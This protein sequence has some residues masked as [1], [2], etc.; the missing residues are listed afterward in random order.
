LHQEA[1]THGIAERAH[2]P[3]IGALLERYAGYAMD[4]L[5]APYAA[6]NLAALDQYRDNLM[7]LAPD[8]AG[9]YAY[10]HYGRDISKASGF[11]QTGRRVGDM[12]PAM[13][14]ATIRNYDHALKLGAA[15]YTVQRTA[16]ASRASVWESLIMPVISEAGDHYILVFTK[17]V[18]LREQL[19]AAVL[20]SSTDGVFAFSPVRGNDGVIEDAVITT[21][22]R[23]GAEIIGRK[24][25]SLINRS[26][27]QNLP[28]LTE[29]NLW[30]R[31]VAVMNAR[32]LD[33][34]ETDYTI[35]GRE[36]WFQIALTAL[37]DGLVM[38]LTDV[39]DLKLAN[40]ALQ[41]RAASLAIEV[42][43]E[44]ASVQAL[45][46][47]I[48]E[49]ERREIELRRMAETDPLTGLLN[50]RV[51]ADGV[52]SAIELARSSDTAL[53]VMVI[54]LDLFKSVNDTYGHATGDTVLKIT[55]EKLG[56]SVRR[57][58]DLVG[59]LGGEE[60]AICLPRA[61][62]AHGRRI[63]ESLRAALAGTRIPTS[64]GAFIRVT[65]SFGVATLLPGE[66]FQTLF[67]R[68]D[69]AL[70]AA[71]KAGRNCVQFARPERKLLE[72]S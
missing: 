26:A 16:H 53:T 64:C 63:A 17:P 50:R 61:E 25:D 9:D 28:I 15:L 7:I 68:A 46:T 29:N 41:S 5:G 13:A 37:E 2:A 56:L 27:L 33:R 72:N 8:R 71:K 30:E 34:F 51:F 14:I 6:F 67:E 65:A 18:E 59:R 70:Y 49:R 23:R 19:L 22:N 52:S 20:D 55:A 40:L 21:A 36:F 45:A 35:S 12:P 57:G 31:C 48:T 44:R 4:G 47:E 39:T 11:D 24:I 38:T 60:F 69:Q 62:A 66:D 54:D 10:L 1:H 43:R 3:E 32:K 42:G 58:S